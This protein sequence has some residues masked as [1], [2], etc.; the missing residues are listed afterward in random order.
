MSAVCNNWC[1]VYVIICK[2][3]TINLIGNFRFRNF[4]SIFEM[5]YIHW[6]FIYFYSN[7]RELN[8]FFSDCHNNYIIRYEL[9]IHQLIIIALWMKKCYNKWNF[10]EWIQIKTNIKQNLLIKVE[11]HRIQILH[12]R[13]RLWNNQLIIVLC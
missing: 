1:L 2:C 10:I 6:Q 4:S 3:L 8:C 5:K 7:L 9:I 12:F 13:C 11:W